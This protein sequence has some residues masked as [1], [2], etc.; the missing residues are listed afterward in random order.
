[1]V[2]LW[3][4]IQTQ[5]R[6]ENTAQQVSFEW[7]HLRWPNTVFLYLCVITK[8]LTVELG[9]QNWQNASSTKKDYILMLLDR[10][11]LPWQRSWQ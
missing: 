1:M 6:Q 10:V 9:S 2:T 11:P 3:D 8:P 5:G 7:P 4:F